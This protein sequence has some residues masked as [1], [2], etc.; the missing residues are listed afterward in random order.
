MTIGQQFLKH[1]EKDRKRNILAYLHICG[2]DWERNLENL[3]S[4]SYFLKTD[5]RRMCFAK[6]W[7]N[8]SKN[9]S[10]IRFLIPFTGYIFLQ[11]KFCL[12]SD[13]LPNIVL[14]LWS[15]TYVIT[16]HTVNGRQV[17]KSLKNSFCL[18]FI[19]KIIQCQEY[20]NV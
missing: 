7:I 3:D 16:H 5:I 18:D 14:F 1:N 19:C 8:I 10:L 2:V 20:P 6:Y 13:S 9:S 11:K 4:S 15:V 12:Q 17:F